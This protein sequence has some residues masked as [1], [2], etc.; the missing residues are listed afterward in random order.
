M[1]TYAPYKH[2][3]ASHP[4]RPCMA[5]G[6]RF[7]PP[8]V[9]AGVVDYVDIDA[10]MQQRRRTMKRRDFSGWRAACAI[11]GASAGKRWCPAPRRADGRRYS[12]GRSTLP[13]DRLRSGADLGPRVELRRC[14]HFRDAAA[15]RLFGAAC[16]DQAAHGGGDAGDLGRFQDDQRQHPPRHLLP[17]RS[18]LQGQATRARRGRLRLSAQAHGR[19]ALEESALDGIESS[20]IVGLAEPRKRAQATGKFDYDPE[21]EGIRVL[22]RYTFQIKLAEPGA[23]LLRTHDRRAPLRRRRAR[24]RR[25]VSDEIMGKPVGTGPIPPREVGALVEDRARAQPDLPR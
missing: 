17:G 12:A 4:D 23:A 24:G 2:Q 7:P 6:R 3:R 20:Q 13:R 25:G 1:T 19:S 22:D 5:V 11:S 14:E 9:L 15:V 16:T 21:I 18:S 8:A 10:A